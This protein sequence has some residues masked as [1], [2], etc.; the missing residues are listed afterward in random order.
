VQRAQTAIHTMLLRH[1]G[2]LATARAWLGDRADL[3]ILSFGC[4]LGDELASIRLLFPAAKVFGCD[5][6]AEVL[7]LAQGS[8]GA[9][10]EIFP[11]SEA[12]IRARGPFDLV[13]AF[14]CLCVHPPP[15][16][17]FADAFPHSRFEDLIGLLAEVIAPGGALA[18]YNAAYLF[19]R[20]A[21]FGGFTPV[22]SDV[23]CRSGFTNLYDNSGA[24]MLQFGTSPAGVSVRGLRAAAGLTDQEIVDCVFARAGGG[25]P[26]RLRLHDPETR[27][28]YEEAFA[29]TR[30]ELDGFPAAERARWIDMR[31]N[32]R[33]YLGP[34]GDVVR[35]YDVVRGSIAGPGELLLATY[36]PFGPQ[37][38][39]S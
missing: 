26:I 12:A 35:E 25:E 27:R 8:V 22:R 3:R 11:A 10:A 18:L 1:P 2:V 34:Y 16:G 23:I 24:V 31:R 29:W 4:S 15:P 21:P 6:D 5:V 37:I 14:S 7:A 33:A 9:L 30:S 32:Y 19:Q 38:G 13:C 36:G 17:R 39:D 28:G 20:T